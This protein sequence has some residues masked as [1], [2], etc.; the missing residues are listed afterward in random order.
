MV[1]LYFDEKTAQKIG[2]IITGAITCA[3]SLSACAGPALT[4]LDVQIAQA[5]AETARACYA[6]RQIPAYADA[7]DAALILMAQSLS[8]DP[9]RQTNV[10]DARQA[11]A[12][13]QN[14][15]AGNIVGTAARA[16]TTAVGIVAGADVAKT[17]L[18]A[19]G[20]KIVGDRNIVTTADNRSQARGP[21]QSTTTTTTTTTTTPDAR[22]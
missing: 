2:K 20:S 13:G 3:V 16:V 12:A 18:K 19:A 9:C 7:R 8:G 17:A 14:Q 15:A 1:R 5:Q 21:D 4:A 11:I 10:Y 6:A 22:P